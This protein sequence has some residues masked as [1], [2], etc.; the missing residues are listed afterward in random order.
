MCSQRSSTHLTGRPR[1]RARRQSRI[2]SGYVWILTPKAPP[3]SGTRTRTRLSGSFRLSQM[4]RL[5]AFGTWVEL[6]SVIVSVRGSQSAIAPR[7]SIG[8]PA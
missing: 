2:S 3:T 6:V 4:S 5:T 1:R 8:I 7:V